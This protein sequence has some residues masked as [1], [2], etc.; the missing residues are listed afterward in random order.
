MFL[1]DTKSRQDCAYIDRSEWLVGG[2]LGNAD[3]TDILFNVFRGFDVCSAEY[4]QN[5]LSST[6]Q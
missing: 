2:C 5:M 1:K 3:L 6:H 4:N